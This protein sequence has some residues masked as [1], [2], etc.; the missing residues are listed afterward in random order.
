M[1]QYQNRSIRPTPLFTLHQQF[2]IATH[3][4]YGT[5]IETAGSDSLD[6]CPNINIA[7]ISPASF[8]FFSSSFLLL[9]FRPCIS[10]FLYVDG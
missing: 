5:S 7:F 9:F 2:S 6:G 8:L 10:T 1:V 4:L 3:K